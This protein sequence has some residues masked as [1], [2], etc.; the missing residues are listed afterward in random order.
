ME[1]GLHV[2]NEGAGNKERETITW[3][4]LEL[5]QGSPHDVM[6]EA[7]PRG[8]TDLDLGVVVGAS[9]TQGHMFNPDSASFP[10]LKKDNE[11]GDMSVWITGFLDKC[12]FKR[13]IKFYNNCYD[14][15]IYC[16]LLCTF[17]GFLLM[18]SKSY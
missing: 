17:K 11:L 3:S 1:Q 9:F 14:I 18:C 2:C 4:S 10:R 8:F 16:F 15:Y 7:T 13:N 5:F 12:K 6:R